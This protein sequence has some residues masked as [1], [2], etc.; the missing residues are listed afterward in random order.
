MVTKWTGEF[1]KAGLGS[2]RRMGPPQELVALLTTCAPHPPHASEPLR[3]DLPGHTV[4]LVW[5]GTAVY[6]PATP[7]S[8]VGTCS[9]APQR[10]PRQ[11]AALE[12]TVGSTLSFQ[13]TPPC[14]APPHRT[15]PSPSD[16]IPPNKLKIVPV[17]PRAPQSGAP[18]AD[19]QPRRRGV[20]RASRGIASTSSSC[21]PAMAR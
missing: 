15:I 11:P 12:V 17:R 16:L 2:F 1:E 18:T 3:P 4:F 13:A 7:V 21:R 9:A 5:V 6:R 10:L 8:S 20:D 19:E 14:G